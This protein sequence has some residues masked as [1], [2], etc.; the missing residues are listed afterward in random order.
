MNLYRIYL[1]V[2][3]S[4]IIII[5]ILLIYVYIYIIIILICINNIICI[6]CLVDARGRGTLPCIYTEECFDSFK[7]KNAHQNRNKFIV[8]VY[9]IK[10]TLTYTHTSI[11]IY[12]RIH[13]H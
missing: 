1:I 12:I 6:I 9:Y 11:H 10:P 3:Y 4:I 2:S 13:I 8:M 5:N 7:R